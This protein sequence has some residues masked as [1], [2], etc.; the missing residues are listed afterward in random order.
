MSGPRLLRRYDFDRPRPMV[1][2]IHAEDCACPACEPYVPSAPSRLTAREIAWWALSGLAF[3]NVLA[4]VI[5]GP[6]TAWHVLTAALTG[7]PL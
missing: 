5:L 4:F 1:V 7:Q 3:G 2:E 6:R